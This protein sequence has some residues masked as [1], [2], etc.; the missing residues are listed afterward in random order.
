MDKIKYKDIRMAN[1]VRIDNNCV[2]IAFNATEYGGSAVKIGYLKDGYFI[3]KNNQKYG[4]FSGFDNVKPGAILAWVS[5]EPFIKKVGS[6]SEDYINIYLKELEREFY[7][8]Y[9]VKIHM[10]SGKNYIKR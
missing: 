4:L 10:E 3:D 9:H 7:R 5:E 1:M 2:P 8:P 6:I